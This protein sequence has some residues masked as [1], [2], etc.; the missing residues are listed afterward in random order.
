[1]EQPTINVQVVRSLM[2]IIFEAFEGVELKDLGDDRKENTALASAIVTFLRRHMET[3]GSV[4][5][6]PT[7]VDFVQ[8]IQ[9]ANVE[10]EGELISV[11]AIEKELVE[12]Y[13]NDICDAIGIV[14]IKIKEAIPKHQD[15]YLILGLLHFALF[16]VLSTFNMKTARVTVVN[17]LGSQETGNYI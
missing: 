10:S 11:P 3:E 6:I 15:A 7:A 17:L 14:A 8:T 12:D 5:Y 13:I 2:S 4:N 9:F 16:V 1:M